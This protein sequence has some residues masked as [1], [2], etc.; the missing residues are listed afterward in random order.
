MDVVKKNQKKKTKTQENLA[1]DE[2]GEALVDPIVGDADVHEHIVDVGGARELEM[3]TGGERGRIDRV[4]I[5]S[6][7]RVN[8][9]FHVRRQRE[10]IRQRIQ[11][12]QT[13]LSGIDGRRRHH[14]T[15]LLFDAA[16]DGATVAFTCRRLRVF[17]QPRM[18]GLLLTE[19]HRV[20]AEVRHGLV[21]LRLGVRFGR[22]RRQHRFAL[23]AERAQTEQRRSS[24]GHGHAVQHA[25]AA[26]A[27]AAVAAAS[28]GV[29]WGTGA[30]AA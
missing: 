19:D 13:R 3:R 10:E 9:Q 12:G 4:E 17:D 5:I 2:V 11:I 18:S 23:D 30:G 25:A 29:R 14:Q 16:R 22:Q 26:A 24:V 15:R 27:A 1:V 6:C 20:E 21:H 8:V 28:R 7:Q